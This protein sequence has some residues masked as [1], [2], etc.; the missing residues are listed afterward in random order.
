MD[1]LFVANTVMLHVVANITN[2][3]NERTEEGLEATENMRKGL[4]PYHGGHIK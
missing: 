1:F 3:I 4:S 2:V